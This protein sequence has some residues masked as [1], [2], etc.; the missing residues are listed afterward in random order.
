MKRDTSDL[1][2]TT[3]CIDIIDDKSLVVYTDD[4]TSIFKLVG[5]KYYET[6]SSVT[7]TPDSTTT[8]YTTTE[9]ADI[10]SNFDFIVPIYHT[11]AIAS[12]LILFYLAYKL[13]LYPFFRK[14][15]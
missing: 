5:N 14:R 4:S 2:E 6:D 7:N 10:S 15:V 11:I 8:C 3:N 12:V 13:I 1:P 9:I